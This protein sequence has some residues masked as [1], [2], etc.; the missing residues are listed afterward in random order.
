MRCDSARSVV[1]LLAAGFEAE[2][3]WRVGVGMEIW[4]GLCDAPIRR[5]VTWDGV[6][7]AAIFLQAQFVHLDIAGSQP[8]EHS[9][10][11]PPAEVN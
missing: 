3:V 5:L 4:V 1:C 6:Y 8:C 9:T 2:E 7:N 11:M 10:S